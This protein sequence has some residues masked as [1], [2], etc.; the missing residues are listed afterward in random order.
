MVMFIDH[1]WSATMQTPTDSQ[2]NTLADTK[3]L[4]RA[5]FERFDAN[6]IDGALALFS[7]DATY[8][9]AGKPDELPGTGLLS[10]PQIAKVFRRMCALLE[11]GLRMQVKSII[12]EGDVAAVEVVSHG[13][14]KNGRHYDN[15]YHIRMQMRDGLIC[16]VR[17]YYDSLH[18]HS[19]W[20]RA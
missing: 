2:A 7:E 12:A 14:L 6:D 10:K 5:F 18:V 20:Y 17:E 4:A 15:E 13:V 11:D 1:H 9:L 19:V 3:A 16:A 8:W